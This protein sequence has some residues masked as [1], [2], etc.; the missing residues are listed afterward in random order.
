MKAMLAYV[1]TTHSSI[2]SLAGASLSR[3]T[4]ERGKR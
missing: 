4:A 1:L 3:I 2:L